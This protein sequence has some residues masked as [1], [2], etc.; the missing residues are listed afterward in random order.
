MLAKSR[1][2]HISGAAHGRGLG[3]IRETML[4]GDSGWVLRLELQS[5]RE[6]PTR[7]FIGVMM[8][9]TSESSESRSK[10]WG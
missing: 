10:G 9:D 4:R 6:E 7:R 8:K 2:E 1:N 3:E 5:I